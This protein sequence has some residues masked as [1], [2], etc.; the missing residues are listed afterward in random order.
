MTCVCPVCSQ[1]CRMSGSITELQT[2][3]RHKDDSSKAYRERTDTQIASLERQ[4]VEN[5]ERMKCA[6]QQVTEKQQLI[7]KLHG[8]QNT[9]KAFLEQQ[10]CLLEQQRE[11]RTS[12]LEETI[13]CLQTD[14]QSLL[15]RV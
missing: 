4:V 7:D 9:E 3:L 14:K 8:E 1:V 5:T 11:E 12:F 6:E 10:I 13:S 15:D 2:L